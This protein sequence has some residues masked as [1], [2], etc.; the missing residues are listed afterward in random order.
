[1]G[2]NSSRGEGE[3]RYKC[4]VAGNGESPGMIAVAVHGHLERSRPCCSSHQD[5]LDNRSHDT[6]SAYSFRRCAGDRTSKRCC[7]GWK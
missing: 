3:Q 7:V 1:M 5:R 6:R 4:S 2:W